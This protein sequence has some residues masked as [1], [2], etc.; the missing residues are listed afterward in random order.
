MTTVTD[1]AAALSEIERLRAERDAAVAAERERW[2]KPATAALEVLSDMP[3]W[4]GSGH[5]YELLSAAI[6]AAKESKT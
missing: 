4:A 1:L 5:A 6:D 3:T 2:I